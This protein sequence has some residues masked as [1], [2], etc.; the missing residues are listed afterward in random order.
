MADV[1]T[2]KQR[3]F[4]MSRI[5][6]KD[7]KPEMVVRSMVHQMGYRYRLHDKKLPGKPDLV[8]KRHKKIIFVHGCFWHVHNCKYGRV[9]PKTNAEFWEKKRTGN[10][11]RDKVNI[12]KLKKDGWSVLAVWEC[13]IKR[14]GYLEKKL[15]Q[16]FVNS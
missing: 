16:F 5:R 8:L 15:R 13:Q 12:K 4:N 6:G 9:K 7:T 11:E 10:R 1:H 3:S 14:E 2:K